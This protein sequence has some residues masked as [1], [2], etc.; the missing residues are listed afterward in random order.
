LFP[1]IYFFTPLAPKFAGPPQITANGMRVDVKGCD[2][3][4]IRLEGSSDLATW[5]VAGS[6][7]VTNG[8][9]TIDVPA[10]AQMIFY[11]AVFNG[12]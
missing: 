6:G 7:N 10:G 4:H 3:S 5:T 2:G 9:V 11:R 8:V 12:P 1:T